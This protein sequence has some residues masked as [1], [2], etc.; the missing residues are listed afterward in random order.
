MD[1]EDALAKVVLWAKSNSNVRTV[2]LTGS[3]A[4]GTASAL[5]DQDIELHVRNTTQLETDDSWWN[6]LGDVLAVERLEN[7]QDQPTR[8]VYFVGGKLDF[9]LVN[10]GESRGDYDRPFVVLLDKDGDSSGFSLQ[11]APPEIPNQD[12]F[13]ECC[14]WASAAALMMAIAI[15][16]DEPWSEMT[17][18]ADLRTELLRM[19]EWDHNARYGSDRDVRFSGTR[20]RQ[21]MD[22]DLQRG[23]EECASTFGQDNRRALK[24]TFDLFDSLASRV[25]AKTGVG[26]FNLNRV[27]VEIQDILDSLPD[28]Q[29]R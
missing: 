26:P 23:L 7:A 17:R 27:S 3:G 24:A 6:A 9:T 22:L 18:E 11:I 13:D 2:V 1:Y 21:W 19:I 16:R 14:N 25:A 29:I 20:M 4:A 28:R 10:K 8:L 5:S 12:M 15:V